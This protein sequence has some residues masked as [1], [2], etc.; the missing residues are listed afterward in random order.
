MKFIDCYG[1]GEIG[2][3]LTVLNPFSRH[4]NISLKEQFFSLLSTISQLKSEFPESCPFPL[5]F[6]PG[7][8]L[9][10]GV[11]IDGDIF[12]WQTKGAS[13]RWP[14]VVIGRHSGPEVHQL[15]FAKFLKKALSGELSCLA[16]PRE[17][18]A[19]FSPHELSG[20]IP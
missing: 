19:Q 6:E 15:P 20:V 4:P 17:W 9:P 14:V 18:Q 8:L 16:I 3:W 5:L 12:C 7:G 13:G 1:S 11:S 10:W 2:G